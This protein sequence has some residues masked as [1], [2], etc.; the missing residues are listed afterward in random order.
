MSEAAA[1]GFVELGPVHINGAELA[2]GFARIEHAF[3]TV[4]E[5]VTELRMPLLD[6]GEATQAVRRSRLLHRP[7][8]RN[9]SPAPS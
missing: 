8:S 5:V 6:S 2:R 9:E 7:E 1:A 4:D 3:R